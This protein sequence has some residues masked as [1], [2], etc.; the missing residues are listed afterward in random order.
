MPD[1]QDTIAAEATPPGRGS[2]RIVRISGVLAEPILRALFAPEGTAPWDAPRTLCLGEAGRSGGGVLDRALAVFFP[3]P[4]TFTAVLNGK[5]TL[6]AAE[7]INALVS[8][9][10]EAQLTRLGEGFKGGLESSL[11]HLLDRI[12]DLRAAW[13]ARVDFSEDVE[14]EASEADRTLLEDICES[15]EA[16]VASGRSIRYFREGWRLALVGPVNTGK[17]SLFNAL[18]KRQRAL[19]TPHPGTTRDVLEE[20]VMIGGY[21]IVL[22]DTAGVRP[23]E[24]PVESQGV[25]WGM[26][27]ARRADG[28]LFVYDSSVGWDEAA[29]SVLSLLDA[30]P[31]AVAANKC[32]LP[33]KG[34]RWPGSAAISAATGEGLDGLVRVIQDWMES[35]IPNDL[36]VLTSERQVAAVSRARDGCERAKAALREGATEEVALQ[37]IAAA[38]RAL[39]DLFNGGSPED[40]YDRIFSTFCIGK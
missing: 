13:E 31:V 36:R 21:P 15:L 14:E 11:R 37:G 30:P 17:S 19:V 22:M 1:L 25:L 18:L 7:T 29:Q 32:D 33:A 24:D 35:A 5:L 16:F 9:E 8:A 27:A 3:A 2:V 4:A 20:A 39:E 23:S 34:R 12:L 28:T 26:E 6:V 40:L 10:T 38:Q